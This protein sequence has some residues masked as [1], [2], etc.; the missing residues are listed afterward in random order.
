MLG[1]G[2]AGA[3]TAADHIDVLGAAIAQIPRRYRRRSLI[4]SDGAGAS[5]DLL[6]WLT[7]QN[8]VRGRNVEYS[9]GLPISG[10]Y[11]MVCV[12]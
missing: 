12:S 11:Q 6:D 5:H 3:S 8:R 4:R 2:N 1:P 7:D 9:I 10:R